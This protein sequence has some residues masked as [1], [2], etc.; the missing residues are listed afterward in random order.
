MKNHRNTV[1]QKENGNSPEIKLTVIKYYNLIG[2]RIQ[3]AKVKKLQ[4]AARKIR[5]ARL[6]SFNKTSKNRKIIRDIKTL[7]KVLNRN[8]GIEE[9]SKC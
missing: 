1:P 3:M 9:L 6:T 4:K 5:K 8:F 2:E 7:K